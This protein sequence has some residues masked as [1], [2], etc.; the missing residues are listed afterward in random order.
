MLGVLL[1]QGAG[2]RDELANPGVGNSVVDGSTVEAGGRTGKHAAW[3][4]RHPAPWARKIRN[5]VAFWDG[6]DVRP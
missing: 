4:Y 2:Q 5:H 1:E 6:V 3:T